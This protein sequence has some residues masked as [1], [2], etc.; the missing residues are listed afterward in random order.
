MTSGASTFNYLTFR[1][2]VLHVLEEILFPLPGEF[3]EP[4]TFSMRMHDDLIVDVGDVHHQL[5]Y[6][7]QVPSHRSGSSPLAA[8]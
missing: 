8:V 4:N 6:T 5:H 3:G 1:N 7:S 2:S